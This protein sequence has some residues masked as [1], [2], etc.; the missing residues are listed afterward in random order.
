M[1]IYRAPVEWTTIMCLVFALQDNTWHAVS[2]R[3]LKAYPFA[4]NLPAGFV[5]LIRLVSR[6]HTQIKIVLVVKE[7]RS[8]RELLIC[9][10][11]IEAILF[12]LCVCVSN[13]CAHSKIIWER[14]KLFFCDLCYCVV[15]ELLSWIWIMIFSYTQYIN[16]CCFVNCE[17]R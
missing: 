5:Q 8:A 3:V 6:V 11:R 9:A 13:N 12:N 4:N 17:S 2:W 10:C 14:H 16:W 7:R 1:L 15:V